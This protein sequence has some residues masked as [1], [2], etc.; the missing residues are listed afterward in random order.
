MTRTPD[1]IITNYVLRRWTVLSRGGLAPPLDHRRPGL[2]VRFW[3]IATAAPIQGRAICSTSPK[4]TRV[5]PPL[6]VAEPEPGAATVLAPATPQLVLPRKTRRP[7]PPEPVDLTSREARQLRE[8]LDRDHRGACDR[9]R[10]HAA[11]PAPPGR[12]RRRANCLSSSMKLASI[13]GISSCTGSDSAY[14]SS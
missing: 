8:F 12:R 3:R 14:V 7:P 9:F 1:P 10:A 2:Y 13:A 4:S 5:Q 6:N 11:Q